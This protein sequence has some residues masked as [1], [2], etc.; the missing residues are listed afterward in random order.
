MVFNS[1]DLA[2]GKDT[3]L[4]LFLIGGFNTL[5]IQVIVNLFDQ[6]ETDDT[7]VGGFIFGESTLAAFGRQVVERFHPFRVE[8]FID[9]AQKIVP[10]I[11]VA[12][13]KEKKVKPINQ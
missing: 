4:P 10:L 7:V 8:D 1:R 6:F 11:Y 13:R 2:G 12:H 9:T 3:V 5:E